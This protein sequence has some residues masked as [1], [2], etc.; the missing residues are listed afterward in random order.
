MDG[1]APLVIGARSDG[2]SE[3]VLQSRPDYDTIVENGPPMDS[4]DRRVRKAVAGLIILSFLCCALHAADQLGVKDAKREKPLPKFDVIEETVVGHFEGL[5][6]HQPGGILARSDVEPVYQRLA[7]M[8]WPVADWKSIVDRVPADDSFLVRELRT[9]AG[10]QFM[11]HVSTFTLGY[12]RLDRLAKLPRGQALIRQLIRGPD[13]YKMIEYMTDTSGGKNLGGMLSQAPGG[14]DF[15][16]AT[17]QI[18]TVEAFVEV[19]K[20]RYNE[21]VEARKGKPPAK[22]AKRTGRK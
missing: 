20:E 1:H 21:A 7:A 10:R 19:L 13:G 22:D 17:G 5:P 6:D 9:P 11:A 18:Y 2:R 12:D 4:K 15:N 8:G 16:K 14:K 3:K